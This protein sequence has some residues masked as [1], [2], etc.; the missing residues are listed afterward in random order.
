MTPK[1]WIERYK[2]SKAKKDKWLHIW[3]YVGKYVHTRKQNFTEYND[4]GDFLTEDIF[5]ST[6]PK[7]N[8]KMAAA[9][10][11]M[12]WQSGGKSVRIN[13]TRNIVLT[14]E[15]K[16]YFDFMSKTVSWALD[17][18][19]AGLIL[20]LEEY[21]TDQGCFGT[22][23]I[24]CFENDTSA[25]RFQC[26]GVDEITIEE[27]KNGYVSTIYREFE[28]SVSQAEEDYGLENLSEK[29]QELFRNQRMT[30]MV[31]F[32]HIIS[33]DKS[34]DAPKPYLSLH[35]ELG[36][37]KEVKR[38][39]FWEMPVPVSRFYKRRNEIYGRSPA[40]Q[41][42]ADILE[43]NA[44]KEARISAIEKSLDPPLGVYDDAV[45][46]NEEVDTSAGG[47]NV[48]ATSGRIANQNP[49]FPLFTVE[50]IREADK[51]IEDLIRSINE[52]FSIDRLLDFNNET[53]MTLGEAQ[54]RQEIRSEALGSLF[55][56][57]QN[58]LF[59]PLIE[60]AV[61]VL[62]FQGR[63]GV[64]KGSEEEQIVLARGEA[65]YYIPDV[66]A[67]LI[68]RGE[69]FYELEYITPAARMME[70][71]EA[72]GVLRTWEFAMMIGQ[73]NQEVFD[74]L[75]ADE[76]L[77]II[78]RSEGAPGRILLAQ[79]IV[80]EIRARKAQIMQQQQQAQDAQ[81]A[82]QTAQQAGEAGQAI[83]NALP[84]GQTVIDEMAA[85]EGL[86]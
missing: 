49:I 69:D 66:V 73:V 24:A 28:I 27:G 4:A 70:T 37:D 46:G 36:P 13:P 35:I 80:D 2:K 40:M 38:S 55:A 30:E 53:R 47:L 5:D 14:D 48:F 29:T 86:V 81:V 50:T 18:P 41:A 59:T 10:N 43:L 9:L 77:K 79:E 7:A 57:Q 1:Q 83:N 16:K 3:Q 76:S 8:Q 20:A 26:W 63:L 15:V 42:L 54:M 34:K 82:I 85:M 32:L 33:P 11:G 31:K 22:S 6:A 67:D 74:L 19:R 45:L 75:D 71:R 78:S 72:Q 39:G 44:T 58:E 12:L 17:D 68:E 51:S 23:G 60:R 56:R 65:P 61:S 52:H 84:E 64:I 21:M 25:L 62:Y